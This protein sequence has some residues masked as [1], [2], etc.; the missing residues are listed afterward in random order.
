[1]SPA[2]RDWLDLHTWGLRE[3]FLRAQTPEE[4]ARAVDAFLEVS[5]LAGEAL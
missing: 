2:A 4:T 3:L 5:R 1:M